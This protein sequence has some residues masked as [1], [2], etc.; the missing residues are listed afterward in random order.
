MGIG[1]GRVVIVDM[2]APTVTDV[3]DELGHIKATGA[4]VKRQ[5]VSHIKG[6]RPDGSP[7]SSQD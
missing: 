2:A 5:I 6:T 3:R 7:T 1:G 4:R